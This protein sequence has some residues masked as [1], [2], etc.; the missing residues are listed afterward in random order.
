[1]ELSCSLARMDFELRI[2]STPLDQ[3]FHPHLNPRPQMSRQTQGKGFNNFVYF[4][5]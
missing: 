5:T 3:S 4:T 1:M 2:P